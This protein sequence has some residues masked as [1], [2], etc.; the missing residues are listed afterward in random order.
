MTTSIWPQ[1]SS[2]ENLQQAFRQ[3]LLMQG[4]PLPA[5]LQ[6]KGLG[7]LWMF[8]IAFTVIGRWYEMYATGETRFVCRVPASRMRL[9]HPWPGKSLKAVRPRWGQNSVPGWTLV[10]LPLIHKFYH[11]GGKKPGYLWRYFAYVYIFLSIDQ[12]HLCRHSLRI[13]MRMRSL[14]KRA[15]LSGFG[16]LD[17]GIR[18][19]PFEFLPGA[20]EKS[21]IYNTDVVMYQIMLLYHL[22]ALFMSHVWLWYYVYSHIFVMCVLFAIIMNHT[23]CLYD[24]AAII[25]D[26][27]YIQY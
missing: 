9:P 2:C 18:M 15:V 14:K 12:I 3:M 17:S 8:S 23:S 25:S 26:K 22:C 4:L 20:A 7:L 10:K 5:H 16:G 24:T 19:H 13:W 1:S 6:A 21:G 11:L 27:S